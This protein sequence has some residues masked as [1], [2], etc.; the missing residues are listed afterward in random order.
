MSSEL[1]EVSLFV[2]DRGKK[3]AGKKRTRG[4]AKITSPR[5]KEALEI[6][7]TTIEM[8]SG[9]EYAKRTH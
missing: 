8:Y 6:I 5:E 9:G 7:D 1:R 4:K 2:Q 3:K